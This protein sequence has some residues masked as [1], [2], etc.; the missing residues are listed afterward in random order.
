MEHGTVIAICICPIAG[1]PMQSVTEVGAIGGAGLEG[2][3][4]AS[5]NGSFNRGDQGTRQVTFINALFFEG[6]GFDYLDSRR[7]LVISGV[8]LMWLIGLEFK[9]GNSRMRGVKYCDPC[10]RPNKLS[11]KEASFKQAFFDRGG[12]IAEVLESGI[13]AVGDK[14]IPPP[15]GY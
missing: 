1:A 4:Y 13:I 2:D 6:S 14:L 15:K 3:R 5:G 7:N 11:G 9:I 8:E 10:L 12:L